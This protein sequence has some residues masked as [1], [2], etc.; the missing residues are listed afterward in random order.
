MAEDNGD[1]NLDKSARAK[2]AQKKRDEMERRRAEKV[3]ELLAK[4]HR[5][6]EERAKKYRSLSALFGVIATVF[7]IFTI[8]FQGTIFGSHSKDIAIAIRDSSNQVG[9]Y[10]QVQDLQKSIVTLKQ[11]MT[12]LQNDTTHDKP[13]DYVKVNKSI[14][15]VGERVSVIE[16]VILNNPEKA[17]TIP[18][19]RKDLDNYTL[20]QTTR[21]NDLA[22]NLSN[23]ISQVYTVIG[24]VTVVIGLGFIGFAA[25]ARASKSDKI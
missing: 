16:N 21:L 3:I 6:V 18:L 24:S 11:A 23:S 15:A 5:I 8:V 25:A 14:Q 10:A 20:S 22:Q 12:Q 19:M 17:L 7:G 1:D 9:V 4:Q 2:Q 13:V